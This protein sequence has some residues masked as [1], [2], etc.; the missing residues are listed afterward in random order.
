MGWATLLLQ[1][2]MGR[3]IPGY[4][5]VTVGVESSQNA[6][7]LEHCLRDL[8]SQNYGFGGSAVSGT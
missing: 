3:N 4:S 5:Q 2:T 8:W 1:V 7:S 6:I